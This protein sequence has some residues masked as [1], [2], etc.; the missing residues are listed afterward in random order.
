[1]AR[2]LEVVITGD[3]KGLNR[4]F[5]DARGSAG[6]F[7]KAMKGVG[8]AALGAAGAIG[9][10]LLAT[11]KVGF[12]EISEAQ[13]VAAQ[14][15]AVLK[16][17][18]GAA[19]VTAAG[20]SKLT[21]SLSA[22][23]A[24]DDEAIQSGANLLLTFTNLKNGVAAGDRVFDQATA[25][26]VD[27]SRALNQDVSAS[28]IQLGKALNDPIAGISSLSRVG[29]TF[30][31]DQ[32]KMIKGMV[33]AGDMMGA[34]KT[35][36]AELN[37]EF[38][39]S[40]EAFGKTL[41]GE[42][43]KARNSFDEMAA[44]LTTKLLP[45]LNGVLKWVNGHWP[46]IEAVFD[47]V[48]GAIGT[49]LSTLVGFFRTHWSTIA[50]VVQAAIAGVVAAF[51][52][53]QP[54][55][56]FIGGLFSQLVGNVRKHWDEIEEAVRGATQRIREIF[57]MLWPPMARIVKALWNIMETDLR[58]FLKIIRGVIRLAMA[59]LHGDWGEAWGALKSLVV[60]IFTGIK[61]MIEERLKAVL[62]IA[63]KLAT[64]IGTV[65]WKQIKKG[66]DLID[67]KVLEALRNVWTVL[68][69]AVGSAG[70]FAMNVG[71]A[72]VDGIGDGLGGI[73]DILFAKLKGGILGTF[74]R[75]KKWLR[76][77]SPSQYTRDTI[78]KPMGEGIVEGFADSVIGGM[79][80]FLSSINLVLKAAEDAAAAGRS[81]VSNAWGQ[82]ASD[83]MRAFDASTTIGAG[84]I[85]AHLTTVLAG[86]DR[87][88]SAALKKIERARAALT[89]AEKALAALQ[90]KHDADARAAATTDAKSQL[91]AAQESGDAEKIK[92]AQ[93]ALDNALYN[94][95]VAALERK[96]AQERGAADRKAAHEVVVAQ[97]EAE[98]ARVKAQ[99][100]AAEREKEYTASREL[101]RRHLETML[102]NLEKNLEK[103][104]GAW[105]TAKERV[106]KVLGS[107]GV[108]FDKSGQQLGQAFAK[109]LRESFDDVLGTVRTLA[110]K[111]AAILQL[112]SPAKEGP[113]ASLDRWWAGFAPMLLAGL[114]LGPVAATVGG[115]AAPGA[116]R[117]PVLAGARVGGDLHVHV[118]A[119]TIVGTSLERAAADLAL[120]IANELRRH[121]RRGI[122][123]WTQS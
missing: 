93:T 116:V 34:Q 55:I 38:G 66:A 62:T 81:A 10:G 88:L 110:E 121:D 12:G 33:E 78:G 112:K 15:A 74:D 49:A 39:G 26:L 96:A 53:I 58:V 41:P 28:A 24:V 5:S 104:P 13:T 65:L 42:L 107:F 85:Q 2:K 50:A 86:I 43:A 1:M 118:H 64:S 25:T 4:A 48:F 20:M 101:M 72:I 73:V 122:G 57:E 37:K 9:G 113:L 63:I 56:E 36:L 71:R 19:N 77:G 70:A 76:F 60:T 35:I 119:G 90:A 11:L 111:V 47:A 91:S 75:L 103:Y 61:D 51:R 83:S 89:P 94:Q 44:N 109:G 23:S 87:Q 59:V 98:R 99:R 117:P 16:S 84:R 46:E 3:T 100:E 40:A 120:P 7:G 102:S 52:F 115:A 92:A 108:S 95:H 31:A 18:G 114:D 54:G 105:R 97:K 82:L 22:M 8:V 69:N 29:V 123:I 32:K 6:G 67:Q 80:R 27:M 106:L 79:T 21:S 30:T 68:Q 14:T 45:T 17:T